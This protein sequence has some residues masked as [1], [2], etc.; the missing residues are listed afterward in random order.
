MIRWRNPLSPPLKIVPTL[1]LALG[2]GLAG[3]YLDLVIMFLKQAF[4]FDEHFVWSGRDFL[5]TVPLVHACLLVLLGA[6]VALVN[7]LSRGVVHARTAAW[8][9]ASMALWMALVRV[10]FYASASLVLAL[11]LGRPISLG[12]VGL[13]RRPRAVRW[14]LAGL[15]GLLVLL[16]AGTTGRQIWAERRALA[17][18]PEA[19][20]AASNVVFIVWDTV[21]AQDLSLYGY[22]RETSPNL[23]RWAREGVCFN[24]ALAPAPWT[25]P[26]HSSFFTGRWPFQLDSQW[27]Y[28][29]TAP[30]PTLAEVLAARGYQTAGF[31]AN[32]N[33]CSWE[34]GLDRGFLH[35]ED[36]PLTPRDVL[37]RTVAGAWL[38]EHVLGPGDAYT[39]KWLRLQSRDAR[40]VN[41]A[42][43]D[44][45][46]RRRSDRPYFAFLN[47]FDA[48]QPY[49]PTRE[50]AGRFGIRPRSPWDDRLLLDLWPPPEPRM[51]REREFHL[52]RD[53]YDDCLAFLDKQLGLLLRELKRQGQLD[54]TLIIVTSDH[55]EAFGDHGVFGHSTSVYLDQ[56]AVP[57]VMLGAGVPAGRVVGDPVSLRD[58][59]ATVLDRLGLGEAA[60]LPG[61]SLAVHWRPD[62]D[63]QATSPALSEIVHAVP[64]LPQRGLSRGRMAMSLVA[65]GR[66]YIRHAQ[67][68]EELY[69]LKTDPFDLRNLAAQP[70]GPGA[71]GPFRGLLL[72]TLL[73]EP[74][75][76]AVETAY[77]AAYRRTLASAAIVPGV[78]RLGRTSGPRMGEHGKR[79]LPR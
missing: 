25:F 41:Q 63:P 22:S 14:S 55:G 12:L 33:C 72:E 23:T 42:F 38:L 17:R 13:V 39:H 16:A 3:G 77:M 21:R 47:Y 60:P 26:S 7:G 54:D 57:L 76:R 10:P 79:E 27:N 59:P 68:A 69:D 20:K 5:W 18:L 36:Y 52:V 75:T 62:S 64:F 43:L 44:W 9:F 24:F 67:G 58:L 8:L 2:C 70:D 65:R 6:L 74:A 40:G 28:T 48:H 11:G 1:A 50:Y 15:A 56:V 30:V 61:H 37:G 66:H 29:L 4:W 53:C 73:Q 45:L 51:L 35:Y 32:T 19:E 46:G 71:V 78:A 34:S 49:I 31:V